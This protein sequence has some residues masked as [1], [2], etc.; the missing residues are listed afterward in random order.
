MV[1]QF[2]KLSRA[3][4]HFKLILLFYTRFFKY[5]IQILFLFTTSQD[6]IGSRARNNV[7]A[8]QK[9][10]KTHTHTLKVVLAV[11]STKLVGV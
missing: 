10:C 6:H 4:E 8:T 5:F 3:K 7:Y 9:I 2:A 11:D 1:T